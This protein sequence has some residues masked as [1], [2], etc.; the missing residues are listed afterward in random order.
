[1]DDRIRIDDLKEIGHACYCILGEVF[2]GI[3]EFDYKGEACSSSF[4]IS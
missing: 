3:G 1:M 2:V 4:Q